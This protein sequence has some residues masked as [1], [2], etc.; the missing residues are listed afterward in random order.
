VSYTPDSYTI[1]TGKL[2]GIGE[3]GS[4]SNDDGNSTINLYDE[5]TLY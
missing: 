5:P 4:I 2:F 3:M 1:H